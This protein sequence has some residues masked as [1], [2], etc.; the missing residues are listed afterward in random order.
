MNPGDDLV[1]MSIELE[2]LHDNPFLGMWN[3]GW[4]RGMV[5]GNWRRGRWVG[6]NDHLKAVILHRI[7]PDFFWRDHY[8]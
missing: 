6:I 1:K 7:I 3:L 2:Q 8:A 4:R 5:S